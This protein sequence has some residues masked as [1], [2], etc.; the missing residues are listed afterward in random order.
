MPALKSNLTIEQGTTW[1][2]GWAV[3]YNGDP[4]DET[5]TA[6]GQIRE[7]VSSSEILY[8]LDP[9][10][11]ADGSVVVGVDA[12]TSSAWAWRSAVYDVEVVNADASVVL[13]VAE[14]RVS[15]SL[16]VTR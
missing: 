11:N 4:I 2:H 15:V 1:S 13:R 14:G 6:R 16:E 3:T 12:A 9:T 8:D 7:R 5:W 10:V